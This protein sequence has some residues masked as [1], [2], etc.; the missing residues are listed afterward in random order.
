MAEIKEIR[1]SGFRGIKTCLSLNFQKRKSCRDMIIYG[2]NGTGKSSIT[3]AWEWLQAEKIEHLRKEGAR[4]NSYPHKYSQCGESYIE[5]DFVKENLG[6][7]RL[8]FD[9]NRVTKPKPTGDIDQFRSV[10]PHPCFIRFEDLTRFVYLTKADKF[11]ALAQLMGFMPQVEMQKSLKRVLRRFEELLNEKRKEIE[12]LKRQ[13]GNVLDIDDVKNDEFLARMN[14]ILIQNKIKKAISIDE[15]SERAEI[16]NDLVVNDPI[17]FKMTHFEILKSKLNKP[18]DGGILKSVDAFTSKVHDFLTTEQQFSKILLLDLYK[19]ADKLIA[20]VDESGTPTYS[21]LSETGE[22]EYT[23]P[24]C[25]RIFPGNLKDHIANE[26]NNLKVLK[27]TRDSLEEER[28]IVLENF[29]QI[30]VCPPIFD[31]LGEYSLEYD[32]QFKISNF[33]SIISTGESNIKQMRKFLEAEI[34]NFTQSQLENIKNVLMQLQKKQIEINTERKRIFN[35]ID[36][37]N[38]KLNEGTDNREQLVLDNK[39][40]D[41]ALKLQGEIRSLEDKFTNLKHSFDEYEALV[42]DYIKC[43]ISNVQERFKIISNDVNDFFDILEQDTDGL[44]GAT[45][46]LLTNEDRAVELQINFYGESIYPAYKYLSE[47]QLNSFGLAVFLASSKYFNADF[48]FIILDDIINSFDGYKRPRIIELLKKK[49]NSH[50]LLLLTHDNV[51]CDRLFENFPSSIKKRFTR[52]EINHGPIEADGFTPLEK[53]HRQ[54]ENDEPVEAGRSMGPFLERQFQEMGEKFEMMVKFNRLNTYS[55]DP[56]VDRFRMRI[57]EKLGTEH[58]FY[59]AVDE[60]Y[61]DTGFRN[62]CAHW[63][64][65]AIQLTSEEMN[66]VVDK[67]CKIEN[68]VICQKDDCLNWLEY[69]NSSHEFICPCGSSKLVKNQKPPVQIIT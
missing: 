41:K 27:K 60:L 61:H 3:D 29:S 24:L 34:D 40:F 65:P 58:E 31:E 39:D 6:K 55:L 11:D 42:D 16:L 49:F 37:E 28:A 47:S 14:S 19:Y 53:I 59:I 1:I 51:W 44:K 50:Q 46:K 30:D 67:W 64:D 9:H 26:L 10:A 33:C 52:W 68:L 63:K 48:K 43:S 5:V 25:G 12:N 45:L 2:R 20:Q 35:A 54:L 62:L 23:C 21:Q 38:E 18:K 32:E 4:E 7:I 22:L 36:K 69:K 17:T 56:L 66:A 13:L 8:V 57:K 15:L